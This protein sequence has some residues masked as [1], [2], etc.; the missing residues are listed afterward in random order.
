M[1]P[2]DGLLK[3][4]LL[5]VDYEIK[6]GKFM[7]TPKDELERDS[8]DLLIEPMHWLCHSLRSKRAKWV[9]VGDAIQYSQ[10][11]T[12]VNIPGVNPA[13]S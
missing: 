10:Y 13:P 2:P 8:N 6:N 7:V 12:H 1:L 3:D 9:R 5:A 4:E 11:N